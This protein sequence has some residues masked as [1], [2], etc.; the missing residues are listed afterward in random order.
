MVSQVG[1]PD[2]H[3]DFYLQPSPAAQ[4]DQKI[5]ALVADFVIPRLTGERLLELGV[6]HQVWTDRL[7]ERFREVTTVEGSAELLARLG[8]SIRTPS[9]TPVH[10]LF[11]EYSPVEPFDTVLASY[12]LEH[13]DDPALILRKA[14]EE[15]LKPGGRIV[16]TVPH[17]LSL[18][19]RLG[20]KMGLASYLGELGESD[21]L[22]GHRYVFTKWE[23]ERLLVEAG[24]RIVEVQG[25]MTKLLPNSFLA[26]CTDEQLRGMFE[27]GLELPIEYSASVYFQ[28]EKKPA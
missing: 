8:E 20:V 19:Y 4:A 11:E 3:K 5:M 1:D 13:V 27:L 12:V 21:Y 22:L 2:A 18:H 15:W 26:Q 23:M 6:G 25:L 16:V 28:A 24:F 7:L 14:H 10:S 17:A 9:W